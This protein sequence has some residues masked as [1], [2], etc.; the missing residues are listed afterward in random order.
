[1][2][3]G[4]LT[5]LSVNG[6]VLMMKKGVRENDPNSGKYTLP[7]GNLEP[8]EKGMDKPQGRMEAAVREP[9]EETGLTILNPV[10]RGIVI[11]HNFEREFDNWPNPEDFPVYI[12][13][14]TEYTGE[15]LVEGRKGKNEVPVWVDEKEVPSVSKNIGDEK[16]HEWLKDGRFF[17]GVVKHKGKELDEKGTFVDYF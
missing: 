8:S 1:M 9:Q 7:G 4:I 14:A 10:L 15:L 13:S 5:Y 16:Y 6:K 3:F 2:K 12:Y 11:F 17:V